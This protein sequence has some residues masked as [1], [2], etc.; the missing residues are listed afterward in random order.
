[1]SVSSIPVMCYY[2]GHIVRTDNDV[3]YDG[4]KASIVPLEIPVDCTFEQL[5]DIIFSSTPI[6]KRKFNLILK[7]KYPLKSGNRFQPL[8]IWN[9]SSV[10]LMLKMVNTTAIE[11]IEL[12]VEV[13]RIHRQA[14]QSI[15]VAEIENVAEID[16]GCGPSSGPVL[17]TGVYGDD[18]ACAYEEGNDE[19]DEDVDVEYDDDLHVQADGHVSSFQTTNQVLENERGIFVSMHAL[20][21]DVS[22]IADDD[23]GPDES[24]PIQFHLPPT[25]CF[26]HVENIDIDISSGWTPWGQETT[27]YASGEYVVGQ[28]FNSKSKLQEVAKIYSIR[29]HQEFVIVAFSKKLLVLRCKKAEECQCQCQWKLCAMVVKDTNLF[30]I[31]KYK[32]PHT[33]VNSCLNRDH[34]Q[35]DSKLVAAHIQAI[36]KAQFTLSPAAIQAIVMEKWGYEISY[37]K[38]LDGK[39]KEFRHLFGDF[40]QSYTDLPRLFLAIE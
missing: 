1:M 25:P 33:C 19:S 38:A 32:G 7:C 15:G 36:I 3:K 40:S 21:C 20:S 16:Y 30:V 11:K 12:F 26:E 14:N 8:T 27:S 24:A 31:N 34:H 2:N 39:H 4:N 29:S 17:D 13:V 37:K 5:G 6:D 18:D 28:V 10:H 23:E 22:N 9:D 35:L